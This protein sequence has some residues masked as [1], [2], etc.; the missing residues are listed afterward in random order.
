MTVELWIIESF[1]LLCKVRS[2]II[3]SNKKILKIAVP[4]EYA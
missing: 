1:T 4:V 3:L 2:E